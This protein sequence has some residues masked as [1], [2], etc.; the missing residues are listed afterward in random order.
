MME[1]KERFLVRDPVGKVGVQGGG[2]LWE[3][4]GTT[5]FFSPRSLST[6]NSIS[7]ISTRQGTVG[8]ARFGE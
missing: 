8:W 4:L 6:E 2:C 3:K 1:E 7:L 5:Q